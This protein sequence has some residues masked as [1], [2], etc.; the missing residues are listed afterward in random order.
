WGHGDSA[1]S[2][3]PQ[4]LSR[5]Q[6]LSRSHSSINRRNF[7]KFNARRKWKAGSTPS[8]PVPHTVSSCNRLCRTWL[9]C[10]LRK[11]DKEL[12]CP[13]PAAPLCPQRC[14]GSDQEEERS[15]HTALLHRRRS[16]C[17]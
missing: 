16:S 6:A 12:S 17:S 14:C 13:C 1:V 5:K 8:P 11:E 7:R 3:P 9:L 15:P 2:L 10:D 4:P